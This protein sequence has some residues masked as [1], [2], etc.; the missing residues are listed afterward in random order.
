[1]RR[2]PSA[3]GN[4][5]GT[6]SGDNKGRSSMD[7]ECDASTTYKPAPDATQL[8]VPAMPS[9]STLAPFSMPNLATQLDVEQ[10]LKTLIVANGGLAVAPGDVP[11]M[12]IMPARLP[13]CALPPASAALGATVSGQ[14]HAVAYVSLLRGT[15]NLIG[16]SSV[17]I[18]DAVTGVAAK[19]MATG[20]ACVKSVSS[21]D[22]R[23]MAIL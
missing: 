10:L 11:V 22:E 13:S 4:P 21:V 17:P 16:G 1:M 5:S 3:G 14:G 9:L 15:G 20:S 8:V 23:T 2:V 7:M 12:P 19:R 6:S 18:S